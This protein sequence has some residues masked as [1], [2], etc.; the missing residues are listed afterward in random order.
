MSK[1]RVA[2][3]KTNSGTLA[4]A[5]GVFRDITIEVQES[6][7][8]EIETARRRL[9]DAIESISEA[10]SLYDRDGRLVVA[11]H[12]YGTLVHPEIAD[13]IEPA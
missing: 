13:Q 2:T 7:I 1:F 6:N 4:Q 9:S 3:G 10:F 5:L 11:N 8:R 12:K